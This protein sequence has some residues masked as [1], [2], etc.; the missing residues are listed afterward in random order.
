MPEVKIEIGGRE[1]RVACGAGEE[2]HLQKAAAA[3][4]AEAARLAE[5]GQ[6]LPENTTLMMAGLMIADRVISA[7]PASGG[8]S[9]DA[10]RLAQMEADLAEA[11]AANTDLEA[12][13]AKAG[14]DDAKSG[15][16]ADAEARIE[17]LEADL[18]AA[19][20]S[21]LSMNTK[22]ADARAELDLAKRAGETE[23]S[24]AKATQITD[25][26]AKLA[27]MTEERDAA[28]A[29]VSELRLALEDAETA[30]ETPQINGDHEVLER[31]AAELERLADEME[32]GT[33]QAKAS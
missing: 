21:K 20:A 8:N 31:M 25:L 28:R 15:N 27:D 11:K 12:R 23:G 9:A 18:A 3:L 6:G 2:P 5:G 33:A 10:K 30:A 13:L 19:K 7:P 14:S 22:L 32:A 29:E 1:Y 4:D 26:E 17:A 16:G 24:G